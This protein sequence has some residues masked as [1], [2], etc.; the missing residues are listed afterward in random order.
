MKDAS[1]AIYGA[2]A[3]NGVILVTT[4]RG[5]SGR[6]RVQYNGSLTFTQPTRIPKMLNSY[7]YATYVNEYDADERHGQA[8]LTYSPEAL[9]HYRTGDDPVNYPIQTGGAK[10]QRIGQPN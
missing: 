10:W 5:S 6:T 1:A 8:G 2:R 7:Q 4:K 9:E 3:A